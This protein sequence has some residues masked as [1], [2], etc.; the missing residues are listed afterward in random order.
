MATAT[1]HPV[2]PEL[3]E[4]LN[5]VESRQ[6][7]SVLYRLDDADTDVVTFDDL[8]SAVLALARNPR[9]PEAP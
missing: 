8:V 7:R 1:T 9:F 5:L 4:V 6:R 2:D 3:D